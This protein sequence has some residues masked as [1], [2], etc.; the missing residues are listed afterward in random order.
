M[1]EEQEAGL[2]ER[3]LVLEYEQQREDWVDAIRTIHRKRGKA[4][5]VFPRVPSSPSGSRAWRWARCS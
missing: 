4:G 5:L 3:P 2:Q 1:I